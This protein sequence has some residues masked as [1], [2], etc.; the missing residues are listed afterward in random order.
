MLHFNL[1]FPFD[2]PLFKIVQKPKLKIILKKTAEFDKIMAEQAKEKE[3]KQ[4][5]R[6]AAQQGAPQ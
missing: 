1:H 5:A 3:S 2:V 4:E 6:A